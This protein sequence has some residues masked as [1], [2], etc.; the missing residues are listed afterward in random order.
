MKIEKRVILGVVILL[1]LLGLLIVYPDAFG[2]CQKADTSCIFKYPVFSL[3]EPLMIGMGSMFI[4]IGIIQFVQENT[5]RDWRKFAM[6]AIPLGAILIA[7][8]PVQGSGVIGI[9]SFDREIVTWIVSV[10]FLVVSLI[11]MALRSR[12]S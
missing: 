5:Y 2:L 10:V 4:L 1:V 7:L 3:G 9:P 11:I 6:W 12:R 8:S